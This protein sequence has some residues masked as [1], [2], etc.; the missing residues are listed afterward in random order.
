MAIIG[1]CDLIS[2]RKAEA[3]WVRLKNEYDPA[4]LTYAVNKVF[5][6]FDVS[7]EGETGVRLR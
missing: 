5:D 6:M 1:D 4:G 7:Q 3:A 2:E